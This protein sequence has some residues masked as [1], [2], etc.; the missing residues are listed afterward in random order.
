MS[1]F[2]P[3]KS[4]EN[5]SNRVVDW[6]KYFQ[7]HWISKRRKQ[8]FKANFKISKKNTHISWLRVGRSENG[9]YQRSG[10]VY[11]L[12][13]KAR[14]PSYCCYAV[15]QDPRMDVWKY[16]DFDCDFYSTESTNDTES[17]NNWY[18]LCL[19]NNTAWKIDPV[20]AWLSTY[21]IKANIKS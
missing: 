6:V 3:P 8:I 4:F 20:L 18:R 7:I 12:F 9:S 16:V 14:S 2:E 10:L 11:S 21:Q 17:H 13:S 5:L 19:K 15:F 1:L